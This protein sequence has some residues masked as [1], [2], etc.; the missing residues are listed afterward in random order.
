[1]PPEE[2]AVEART[3]TQRPDGS[4]EL[5]ARL[6]GMW[7]AVAPAWGE[8]AAYADARG[9]G[10][11][12][13]M[14][15]LTAPRPGERVLELACGPGGL[16]LAA[17]ARVEPGGEVVMSDVAAGMTAIAAARAE[18][19]GVA[20]VATRVLD[21]EQIDEPDDSYDVVLCREG[22][23][24][25]PDPAGAAREIRRVL[26][27]GGRVALAVWGLR[28]RNPWLGVV[29]DAVAAQVGRP[30]PPPGVPGP[31]S[32]GDADALRA[33][34]TSAGL[35]GADVGE[36]QVPLRA[37][38]FEEWWE[39]T[40]ALAGP[41]A[42]ILP[43]LPEPARAGIVA[44]LRDATAPYRTASGLDFPGVSLIVSARR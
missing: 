1:M 23:M 13:R 26:R 16:G 24:F 6:H 5:R 15:S 40:S 12:E 25:A 32:L 39:R 20:N 19:L 29:L 43:S 36:F 31:F 27:P 9:A 37:A 4:D 17:A 11:G 33:I 22:L 38:S 7:A 18:E 34:V 10:V 21:L 30:V 44:R 3:I 41:L 2:T 8:H 14:L 28:E 42:A 35:T